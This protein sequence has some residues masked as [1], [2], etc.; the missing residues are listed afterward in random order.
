MPAMTIRSLAGG[1]SSFPSAAALITYGAAAARLA[2]FKNSR[3]VV[4]LFLLI[5]F[6][7]SLARFLATGVSSKNLRE[8]APGLNHNVTLI[9]GAYPNTHFCHPEHSE[10]S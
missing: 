3:R 6:P 2:R 1:R 8:Q 5:F 10:G 4:L 7:L 9:I